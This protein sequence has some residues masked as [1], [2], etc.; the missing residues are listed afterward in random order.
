MSSATS[1]KYLPETMGSGVALFDFNRDGRLDIFFANGAKIEDPMPEGGLPVKNAKEYSN[2][3][4]QQQDDGTFQDVTQQ[5]K[6][7]GETYGTGVAV[8]DYDNDGFPDLFVGGVA[9]NSLYR[10]NGDGTFSDVTEQAGVRGT[11]W[12]SSVAFVDYDNDGRLDLIVGRYLD[13]DFSKNMYCGE[14]PVRAYCSPANFDGIA[15]ILF[16]NEG[17]GRFLDVSE[18]SLV[19]EFHGKALGIGIADI[20][21]DGLTD[22]FIANDG[23]EQFLLHNNGDGTFEEVALFSGV[24]MDEDGNSFAGMGVDVA[25]YDNDTLPDILVTNLSNQSYALYR[26]EGDDG[27][28][29]VS[30][31]S[32]LS[33]I[34]LLFAGWGVRFL[35]YDND[36]WRDIFIIQGHVLDTIEITSPHIQYAQPPFL[37]R[38][39][40]GKSFAN[41]S[42][43]SGEVFSQSHV[44][45][46]LAVGDIDNDGDPDV[47]VSNLDTPAVVFRN[48]GGN[49]Q[50]WIIIDPEG[51][52]SNRDGIGAEIEIVTAG[53]RKLFATVTTTS[54]YQSASDHRVHFGLKGE[55]SITSMRIRWPSGTIQSLENVSVNQILKVIEPKT[56]TG[57]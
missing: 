25:D 34:S 4:F 57:E 14:A 50:N 38:N 33:K 56:S 24:A 49:K 46:G 39:L 13:W 52:N 36:S 51:T 37:L 26:N 20:D 29:Y 47:V 3:L 28:A 8:G 48:E 9:G 19:S 22:I 41:V 1:R 32:G 15:P 12:T 16:H 18:K 55:D 43:G 35:D 53:G 30:D 31:R 40:E 7:Q 5:A 17:G 2:R 6:L 21:R 42:A 23:M 10:N 44:G 11:G 54:S 45:R 27:F